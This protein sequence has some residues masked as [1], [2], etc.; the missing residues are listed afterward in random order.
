MVQIRDEN[1]KPLPGIEVGDLGPKLGDNANDTGFMRINNVRIPREFMLSRYQQVTPDGKYI[2][3]EKKQKNSRLHYT[4]MIF[5]RASMVRTSGGNLAK[6]ATIA[7][8]YSCVR[9]Q[10]YIDSNKKGSYLAPEK[11]IIDHQVQRYR[12]FRQIALAYAIKFTGKQFSSKFL[13]L[14]DEDRELKNVEGLAEIAATS[15]AVK[16]LCTYLAWQGIEDLRKCCGGNGYLMSSGIAPLSANYVWQT[17]AE[18]DWVILM[19]YTA[20]FL[21]KALQSAMSGQIQTEAFDYMVPLQNG[22][23]NP[24]KFHLSTAKS[25]KDFQNLNFLLQ[26][27]K[28]SALFTVTNTGLLFHYLIKN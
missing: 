3:S 17:T 5:T 18:G 12:I 23:Y 25:E 20:Q 24:S 10:G 16:A 2:K 1:H 6:A 7:T 21:L 4:T 9:K 13:T 19:L 8:R 11:Q 14:T 15:G 26:L 28:E 27:F 22:S